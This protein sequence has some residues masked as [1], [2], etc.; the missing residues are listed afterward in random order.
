[1]KMQM[2]KTAK[3]FLYFFLIVVTLFTLFPLVYTV[4]ASLKTNGDIASGRTNIIPSRE[5]SPYERNLTSGMPNIGSLK[6]QY[7]RNDLGQIIDNAGK[8]V[9]IDAEG[10][11]LDNGNSV[12][13]S[14]MNGVA[15]EK[16]SSGYTRDANGDIVDA[17]GNVIMTDSFGQ[18]IQ[19]TSENVFRTGADGQ[20]VVG[21]FKDEYRPNKPKLFKDGKAVNFDTETG[22]IFTLNK[23]QRTMTGENIYKLDE[24][25]ALVENPYHKGYYCYSD[26]ITIETDKVWNANGKAVI[27]DADG[28]VYE[29]VMEKYIWTQNYKTVWT[30][31]G[32]GYTD[33]TNFGDYTLNSL[34]VSVLTVIIT[35]VFTAMS[36]YC[37][38]RGRFP[39]KT[40]LYWFFMATMFI[41][42]GTIT[43]F[44]ILRIT[45]SIGMNNWWGLAIVCGATGGASNLFLTMGYLKTIPKDLD[46]SAKIDGCTFFSTW[47][48]VILP[49][50]IPILGTIALMTFRGSWNN[51]M[52]PRLMLASDQTATTLVVAIV[53]LANSGGA[54]ASQ[55]NLM[56][57][58][59]M[60]SMAPML[61]MFLIMNETFVEG[62]TQ[63][64]VKG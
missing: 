5:A 59:S 63:G 61:I 45:T 47:W 48:R 3:F 24:N 2:S 56:M 21:S 35:V 7:T 36:A 58:G 40:F 12:F 25:G 51:W 43:I 62:I 37:F 9:R 18:T 27:Y 26:D 14:D 19:K 54:G 10:N 8:V 34:K 42:A 53:N 15:S 50:S 64:S 30:M 17:S 52:L 39:G 32:S 1:M 49:L 33:T 38:Q 28:Y 11:R 31:S 13:K 55:Y 16:L 6:D 57:A 60:L 4:S 41:G 20:P 46:E 22:E 29:N 23:G 44:P